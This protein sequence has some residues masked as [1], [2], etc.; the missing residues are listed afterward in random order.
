[1][2]LQRLEYCEVIGRTLL[3]HLTNGT[4]VES[5]GKLDDLSKES[6]RISGICNRPHR[7]FLINL[8]DVRSSISSKTI[9]LEN[10]AEIPI[11][12]G[13]CSEIKNQY[14][15]YVFGKKTGS[16]FIVTNK[17]GDI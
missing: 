16:D 14:L 12:H 2:D 4:V 10:L 1:M 13:K 15:D 17:R 3:F 9:T 8:E 6:G 5:I 11:P 7:S